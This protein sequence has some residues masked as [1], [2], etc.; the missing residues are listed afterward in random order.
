MAEHYPFKDN[1]SQVL[2]ITEGATFYTK[3]MSADYQDGFCYVDYFSDSDGETRADAG[4]II[5]TF[6]STP[7]PVGRPFQWHQSPD[8]TITA[9]ASFDGTYTPIGFEG[10]VTQSR[11]TFTNVTGTFYAR[12]WHWRG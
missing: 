12:A 3:T 8:G 4:D 1:D 9:S 5:A 10:A 2:T 7:I 11:V 6:E